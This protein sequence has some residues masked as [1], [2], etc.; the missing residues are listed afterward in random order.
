M[1]INVNNNDMQQSTDRDVLLATVSS[2]LREAQVALFVARQ[3]GKTTFAQQLVASRR[4]PSRIL[5]LEV[6]SVR[7]ALTQM[8]EAILLSFSSVYGG[9]HGH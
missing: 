5:D 1:N 9:S 8:P 4:G 7:E 3:V 6:P 2:G